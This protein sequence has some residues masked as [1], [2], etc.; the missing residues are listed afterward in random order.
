M[1]GRGD[2]SMVMLK[3]YAHMV[4]FFRSFEWWKTNPD[5]DLVSPGDFCLADTGKTYVV[6]LPMAG[7][8]TVK[9]KPGSYQA[10][11]FNPRTGQRI[12]LPEAEGPK[13]TS[14][15]APDDGDWVILLEKK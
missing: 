10:A 15:E 8:V 3:G 14:P 4:D 11:W 9:L 12:A 1:N 6:Y 13:W 7:K 2:S 5:D